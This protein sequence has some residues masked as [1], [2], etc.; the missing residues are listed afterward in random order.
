M[1][2]IINPNS[3]VSMT[4]A[5]L[6]TARAALSQGVSSAVPPADPK[7][8][9]LGWTSHEGRPSIQGPEDGAASTPPLLR[10]VKKASDSG[11]SAIIIGCAD[12]T[13]LT[14]ARQIAACPV[15]GIGQ[16]ALP[17]VF[18]QPARRRN[19]PPALV[20]CSTVR[21]CTDQL[22]ADGVLVDQ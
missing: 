21:H 8:Q 5:M 4:E 18:G 9:I 20:L 13:G 22:H 15:I 19:T 16:A 14:E 6:E 11:A 3:T 7:T 12:D 10:L 2:V 17:P 1:I